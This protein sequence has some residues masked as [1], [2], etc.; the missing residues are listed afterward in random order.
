MNHDIVDMQG[1]LSDSF[2]RV[3]LSVPGVSQA[4]R[5]DS[6]HRE[7]YK[8][9]ADESESKLSLREDTSAM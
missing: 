3:D 8:G 5:H 7:R 1:E 6:H 2:E 9:F 4:Y